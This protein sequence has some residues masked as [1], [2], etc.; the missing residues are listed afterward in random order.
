MALVEL[1]TDVASWVECAHSALSLK[2]KEFLSS[3][4][5][6]R[7]CSLASEDVG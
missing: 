6:S 3:V 5:L 4:K 2:N 7:C 1:S